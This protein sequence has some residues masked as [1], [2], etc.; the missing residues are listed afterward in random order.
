MSLSRFDCTLQFCHVQVTEDVQTDS[1]AAATDTGSAAHHVALCFGLKR[2]I[3][4]GH[5][6]SDGRRAVQPPV[7]DNDTSASRRRPLRWDEGL[8]GEGCMAAQSLDH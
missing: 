7:T 4:R 3:G 1:K 8:T 2:C 5:F 6:I